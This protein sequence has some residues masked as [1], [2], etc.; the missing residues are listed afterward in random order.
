MGGKG[1]GLL[2]LQSIGGCLKHTNNYE[3]PLYKLP[4]NDQRSEEM[5][6]LFDTEITWIYNQIT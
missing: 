3:L 1:N 5:E 4:T 2:D 6:E